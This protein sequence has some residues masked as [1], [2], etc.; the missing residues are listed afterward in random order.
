MS[1]FSTGSSRNPSNLSR[2]RHAVLVELAVV[3]Y[4]AVGTPGFDP[5]RGGE[6]PAL[7]KEPSWDGTTLPSLK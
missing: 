3:I 1:E 5:D 2:L 6:A 7:R 4:S